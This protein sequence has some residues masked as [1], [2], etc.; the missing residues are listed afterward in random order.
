[1]YRYFLRLNNVF[2]PVNVSPTVN[3]DHPEKSYQIIRLKVYPDNLLIT[4]SIIHCPPVR[5]H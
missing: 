4:E 5:T 1:M 2:T 3:N